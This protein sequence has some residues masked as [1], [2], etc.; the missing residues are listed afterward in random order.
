[1]ASSVQYSTGLKDADFA[2][3]FDNQPKSH[4]LHAACRE[5]AANLVPKQR[6]N[7]IADQAIEDA[8]RLLRVYQILVDVARVREC[9][10]HGLL[11]DLVEC[12]AADLFPFLGVG[13]KLQ[14]KMVGNGLT[15]AVRVG[16]QIRFRR[17]SRPA[18]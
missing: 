3:A 9:F 5:A 16:S 7:L 15:F 18:S 6:G 17:T 11:G 14:R 10:L 12:D 2:L 13:A 4:G 8:A 1:M